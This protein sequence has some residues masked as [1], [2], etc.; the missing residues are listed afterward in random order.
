[1]IFSKNKKEN[2]CMLERLVREGGSVFSKQSIQLISI[3]DF[4]C[5][6][7]GL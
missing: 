6:V 3:H 5:V 4:I 2:E 7:L 1:M